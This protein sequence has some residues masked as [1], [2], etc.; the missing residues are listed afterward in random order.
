[1]S[2]FCFRKLILVAVHMGSLEVRKQVGRAV[3]IAQVGTGQ[4]KEGAEKGFGKWIV[5]G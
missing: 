5:W 4:G 3:Y 1:M 2:D